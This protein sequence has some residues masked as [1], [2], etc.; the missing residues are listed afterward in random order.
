MC[1]HKQFAKKCSRINDQTNMCVF[2]LMSQ[3]FFLLSI[4]CCWRVS[5]VYVSISKSFQEYTN[6]CSLH[7]L[8]N[9]IECICSRQ[10]D[11]QNM[12]IILSTV[13]ALICTLSLDAR[14]YVDQMCL[15]CVHC[16]LK[17]FFYMYAST[18]K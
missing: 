5:C 8:Q 16:S 6:R 2:V 12:F 15:S 7:F 9:R 1:P 10:S 3:S 11:D 17:Q 13:T 4:V 14:R 18:L